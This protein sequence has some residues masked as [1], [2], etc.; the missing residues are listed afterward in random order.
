[1]NRPLA[2]VCALLLAFVTVSSACMA[3]PADWIRFS[4]EQERGNPAKIHASFHQNENGRVNNNWST[5]FIPSDLIGLE[6]ASFHGAGSRPIHFTIMR[7]A[8]RLDCSGTGGNSL[9]GGNCR[10]TENPS[11]EQLLVSSGMGQPTR[12]QAIG[13]M[14]VNAHRDVIDA[15]TAANYPRMNIDNLMALSALGVDGPYISE[16]ARSKYRPQSIQQLVEF[17]ALGITPD[18]I[19]GFVRIGYAD[20]P[21]DGLVQLRAMGITPDFI[22]GYQEI[23]YRNLP[24]ETLVQLKALDITPAFVR[25]VALSDRPMPSV[26]ELVQMKIFGRKR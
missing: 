14:A 9:A 7:E 21:G 16:L 17:K 3:Q 25:S 23:G 4:L 19:A 18:W 12:E 15:A 8:G 11:F 26:S 24:V 6:L 22:R 20:V 13:L 2:F 5:G 10:F 1:M